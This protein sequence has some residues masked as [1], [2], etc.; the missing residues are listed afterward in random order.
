M[1]P[2]GERVHYGLIVTKTVGQNDVL[3]CGNS[4]ALS[5]RGI[6]PCKNSMLSRLVLC[7]NWQDPIQ[8]STPMPQWPNRFIFFDGFYFFISIFFFFLWVFFF[9]GQYTN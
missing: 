8:G 4:I 5:Y 3:G 9:T 7:F 2:R 6:I 1:L